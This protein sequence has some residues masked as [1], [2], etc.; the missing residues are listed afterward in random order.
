[1]PCGRVLFGGGESFPLDGSEVEQARPFHVFDVGE[2]SDNAVDV[3]AVERPEIAYVQP[4]EQVLFV[5]P[6]RFEAVGEAQHGAAAAVADEAQP[7]ERA[8]GF[9][10]QGVIGFRR[11]QVGQIGIQRACRTV[12]RHVVVVEDDEQVG[13][14]VGGIVQ[15]LPGQPS[16]YRGV[17]DD[18]DDIAVGACQRRGHAHSQGGRYAVRGV[19]GRERVVFAFLRVRKAAEPVE[20][21]QG[22]EGVA[23]AREQLVAVG[24]MAHVPYD[25]VVGG[26]EHIVERHRYLDGSH[27]RG[28]MTRMD[29]QLLDEK[30]AYLVA[31]RRQLRRRQPPQ[32]GRAVDLF[33]QGIFTSCHCAYIFYKAAQ[34]LLF[35]RRRR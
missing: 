11:R 34:T 5:N 30:P 12:D 33:E 15:S 35:P 28:E 16:G 4:L 21:A 1:M 29:S 2:H 18:G 25:A 27:R 6:E 9:V 22:V 13:V 14:G 32:I 24:L 19:A 10:A 20:A 23:P 8:V 26:I 7:L 3:V 17:A 31:H